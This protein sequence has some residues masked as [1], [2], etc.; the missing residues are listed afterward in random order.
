MKI[1]SICY[2]TDQGLGILAKD[3][4][5]NGVIDRFVI[6]PHG[7][8]T[9]HPEWYPE[10]TPVVP[11]K[12]LSRDPRVLD[13]IQD[14]DLMLFFETPFD[15]Q[16][17]KIC[18]E[19]K[20]KSILMPMYECMPKI[21]P[22][23]P[24]AFVNPSALDEEYYPDGPFIPIPVPE[25]VPCRPRTRAKTFIHNAGHGGL[26]GRNGTQELYEAWDYVKSDAKLLIRCQDHSLP[27]K[28]NVDV[29]VGTFPYN[30]IWETG[31]VFIFPEKFN[32]LSLPLQEARAAGML[33]MCA[34]RFPMN[35]WLPREPLIPVQQ[36]H[37]T[38][39]APRCNTFGEAVINPQDIAAK[40]DEVY[41]SDISD[42]SSS[43]IE[44]RQS[45][46]WSNLKERYLTYF[47]SLLLER[48]PV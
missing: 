13:M 9:D 12:Y 5:D 32:G 46:S 11:A 47:Q 8:R 4:F 34:D 42:Y 23:Y 38:S 16:L 19:Y 41:N 27:A 33:V 21:L 43:A 24:D 31:D 18:R 40:V 39:V 6:I 26:K 1:G 29:L 36:Y 30:E 3:F 10:N 22:L 28:K 48:R 17:L 7:R 15:W 44:W 35:N 2:A 14:M 25:R 20:T 45:M 37:K